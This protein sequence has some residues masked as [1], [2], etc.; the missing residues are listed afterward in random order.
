MD[1]SG[2]H[3]LTFL[4][5]LNAHLEIKGPLCIIITQAIFLLHI[6]TPASMHVGLAA[7]NIFALQIKRLD[8]AVWR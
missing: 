4:T 2:N 6:Q 1:V 3:S 7:D 8:G 5:F